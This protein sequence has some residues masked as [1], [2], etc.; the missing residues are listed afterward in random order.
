MTDITEKIAMAAR[1]TGQPEASCVFAV[2]RTVGTA[3]GNV[4]ETDMRRIY[5]ILGGNCR[6]EAVA[7][8]ASECRKSLKTENGAVLCYNRAMVLDIDIPPQTEDR[9]RQ[10]AEAAGK[11]MRQYVSEI[12]RQAADRPALDEILEP[13]RRQFSAM[14]VGDDELVGDIAEAQAEYRKHKHKKPA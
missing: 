10:Q 13:L 3:T 5:G 1:P 12:I 14:G 4:V 11:D 8:V 9:L 7:C 6:G 2:W